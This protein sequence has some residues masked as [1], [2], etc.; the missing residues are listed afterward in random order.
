MLAQRWP[1]A[2]S[3]EVDLCECYRVT[4]WNPYLIFSLPFDAA[5]GVTF[6]Q[7]AAVDRRQGGKP[8]KCWSQKKKKKKMAELSWDGCVF[9]G[10]TWSCESDI[11]LWGFICDKGKNTVQPRHFYI[12]CKKISI[13]FC[14][15]AHLPGCELHVLNSCRHTQVKNFHLP[16]TKKVSLKD[17]KSKATFNCVDKTLKL[18][19]RLNFVPVESLGLVFCFLLFHLSLFQMSCF[20]PADPKSTVWCGRQKWSMC[21]LFV[22]GS[23]GLCRKIIAKKKQRHLA[24]HC[25]INNTW[26]SCLPL[27]RGNCEC[28]RKWHHCLAP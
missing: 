10:L 19:L 11:C 23:E 24:F 8:G 18:L 1:A 17:K 14:T 5:F 22:A 6:D 16:Q 15:A 3:E 7:T 4:A 28:G 27:A 21:F 25:R 13:R 9:Q 12:F 26:P 20:A 2:S